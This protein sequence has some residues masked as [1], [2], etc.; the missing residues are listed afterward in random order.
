M[1]LV[2]NCFSKGQQ[3]AAICSGGRNEQDTL[4]Q[5]SSVEETWKSAG[6]GS[7]SCDFKVHCVSL[8]TLAGRVFHILKAEVIA[9]G[10][11]C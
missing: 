5:D 4:F 9:D 6:L 7:S 3:S 2:A 10:F 11:G 8:M 1:L